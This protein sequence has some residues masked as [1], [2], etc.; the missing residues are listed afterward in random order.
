M[1][2]ETGTGVHQDAWL[3]YRESVKSFDF[4]EISGRAGAAT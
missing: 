1:N 3:A 4:V 2:R